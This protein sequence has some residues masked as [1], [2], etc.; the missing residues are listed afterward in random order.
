VGR[1]LSG[2]SAVRSIASG[3]IAL[4]QY[5]VSVDPDITDAD[6][7]WL[8]AN[9][10]TN[11]FGSQNDDNA[12]YFGN[13]NGYASAL[14]HC[15]FR[16]QGVAVPQGATID[17]AVIK[18]NVTLATYPPTG[19]LFGV[20]SDNVAVWDDVYHPAVVDRTTASTTIS[21]SS[22]T[23]IRT[24][25]I[26]TSIQEIV[27]RAGWPPSFRP[28]RSQGP[29][30]TCE[31]PCRRLNRCRT[32]LNERCGGRWNYSTWNA[33]GLTGLQAYSAGPCRLSLNCA[34]RYAMHL[35]CQ[36]LHRMAC[37]PFYS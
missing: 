18:L 30:C 12:L 19:T 4:P 16:F 1:R 25:D 26:T 7:T 17:Q 37:R 14:Q 32:T 2:A 29:P 8:T 33:G 3:A 20:D 6:D 36:D 23:G 24:Y 11:T 28:R 5:P 21:A 13:L 22:S 34:A 27:N 15:G 31:R 10:T 35:L 9:G